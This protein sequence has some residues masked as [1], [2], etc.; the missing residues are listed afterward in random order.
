MSLHF[1]ESVISALHPHPVQCRETVQGGR[2]DPA[3]WEMYP[4][5]TLGSCFHTNCRGCWENCRPHSASE[6][7]SSHHSPPWTVPACP[8]PGGCS[9]PTPHPWCSHGWS[10]VA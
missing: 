8:P 4:V 9:L 5:W 2:R 3:T 10:S 1:R 6:G 7:T